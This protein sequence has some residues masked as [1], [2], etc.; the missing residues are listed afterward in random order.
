MARVA[1][2]RRTVAQW[3]VE[4][5]RI[6]SARPLT[7]K[8]MANRRNSVRHILSQLGDRPV[9]SVRP[10]D[11][12]TT[13]RT[14]WDAGYATT[15]RIVLV[16]ARDMFD[17][18][19]LAGW[20]DSNPAMPVKPLPVRVRRRRLSL[21]QWRVMHADAVTRRH[22]RWLPHLLLLAVVTG[23]RRADLCK[24]RFADV[25]D[26]YLQIEQQKTGARI[27]LPLELR[28]DAIG[29]TLGEVIDGCREYAA[30]GATLLRKPG[31]RPLGESALTVAFEDSRNRVI[32]LWT[33]PGTPP[34]LHECRSLSERLYRAQGVDTQTLLGHRRQSMTD[35]YN[36]DRG[37]SHGEW[38]RLVL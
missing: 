36:D 26:G 17:Q 1:P 2:G 31:G 16:E 21:S 14:V 11:I 20:I 30:P 9:R 13:I 12:A 4:Y 32:G 7:D 37:L 8:T 35:A 10:V 18:A 3:S 38:K 27:A 24:M 34:T 33:G 6:I 22:Q 5:D 23:Q 19:M 28:L 15:A 29:A 25:V